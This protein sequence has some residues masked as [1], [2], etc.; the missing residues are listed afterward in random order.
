MCISSFIRIVRERHTHAQKLTN[1]LD[2]AATGRRGWRADRA[3]STFPSDSAERIKTVSNSE[4]A[5]QD[6]VDQQG[7]GGLCLRW[8]FQAWTG[9]LLLSAAI[10]AGPLKSVLTQPLWLSRQEALVLSETV[11]FST[12]WL[13]I[14]MVALFLGWV[15]RLLGQSSSLWSLFVSLVYFFSLID[16]PIMWSED[17]GWSTTSCCAAKDSF[18]DWCRFPLAEANIDVVFEIEIK[19]EKKGRPALCSEFG[20]HYR[21]KAAPVEFDSL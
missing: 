21:L 5:W 8:A 15:T 19:A 4:S 20:I 17:A 2:G 11:G 10:A 14:S 6:G 18:C 12:L 13:V 1:G 16:C 7:L 9:S 3:C